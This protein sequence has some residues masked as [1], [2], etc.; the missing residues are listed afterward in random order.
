MTGTGSSAGHPGGAG[1]RPC[2]G[3]G[4]TSPGARCAQGYPSGHHAEEAECRQACRGRVVG[5]VQRSHMEEHRNEL[6]GTRLWVPG[7]TNEITCFAALLAL[8]TLLW[9]ADAG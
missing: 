1:W 7:K 3:P 2:P 8:T 5:L 6:T 9:W 4:A